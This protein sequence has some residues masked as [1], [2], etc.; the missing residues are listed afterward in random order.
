MKLFCPKSGL[1]YTTDLGW[2]NA[3]APHPIF[4]LPTKELIVT[5]LNPFTYGTLSA[6]NTHLLGCALLDKFP[7]TWRAPVNRNKTLSIWKA[8]I[9][10]LAAAALRLSTAHKVP[11]YVV[12]SNS[13]DLNNL[14]IY[15]KEVDSALVDLDY[16]EEYIINSKTSG[17]SGA[18]KRKIPIYAK[19]SAEI[20]ILKLL[21]TPLKAAERQKLLPVI[22]AEWAADVGRFPP[23]TVS[24]RDGTK[25]TLR[26]YWKDIIIKIFSFSDPVQILS[27]DITKA[28]ISELIEHCEEKIDIGTLHSLVLFKKLR[29]ANAIIEEFKVPKAAMS[30]AADLLREDSS[31]DTTKTAGPKLRDYPNM[32]AFIIARNK[33]RE[34]NEK[35]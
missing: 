14:H 32:K 28:D 33:W 35:Q 30:N 17:T 26:D 24:L 31:E 8:N 2:G 22:M 23:N 10:L 15:L 29:V 7:T 4:N 3:T 25:L 20:L 27:E 34:L 21:R 9:E 13:C 1:H 11:G 5:H 18:N 19:E 12:D 16:Q 6:N